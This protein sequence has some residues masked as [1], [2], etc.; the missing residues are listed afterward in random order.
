MTADGITSWAM[1]AGAA[2]EF[3]DSIILELARRFQAPGSEPQLT[4]FVAPECSRPPR[5]VL[6]EVPSPDLVLVSREIDWSEK[7]TETLFVCF[8]RNQTLL[9]LVEVI[10]KL[11]GGSE[12]Y[13]I[14]PH[15]S[16]IY[17]KLP[18]KTKR[19]L[20]EEIQMPFSDVRF[21][22]ICAMHCKSPT[23]PVYDV[24]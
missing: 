3:V 12:Q 23:K 4:V 15:L 5:E 6:S 18:A 17:K 2:R 19:A 24:P 10:R 21:K 22:G 14:D 9:D 20:A 8:E 11:S 13:Q 7:F 16:L 1:P